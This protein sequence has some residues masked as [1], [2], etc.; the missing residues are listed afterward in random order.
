MVALEVM[1]EAA[2]WILVS[3]VSHYR[4]NS[5]APV[6]WTGTSRE[7]PTLSRWRKMQ[8]TPQ[9]LFHQ[10]LATSH[11]HRD[12]IIQRCVLAYL[13]S[14]RNNLIA[15]LASLGS[16][17]DRL[18][19]HRTWLRCS[20]RWIVQEMAIKSSK[21]TWRTKGFIATTIFTITSL[22]KWPRS[23]TKG[24][25]PGESELSNVAYQIRKRPLS[26]LLSTLEVATLLT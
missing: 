24:S 14:S 15:K 19:I 9:W 22:C 7:I 4:S 3:L 20:N 5:Q 17:V 10:C 26:A 25:T 8:W 2:A 6:S 13:S 18:N 12:F 16:K 21:I 11:L 23:S 1:L